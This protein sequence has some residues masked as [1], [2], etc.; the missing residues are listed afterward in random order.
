M[1]CSL[2]AG[3]VTYE[4]YN[5]S[6]TNLPPIGIDSVAKFV[7]RQSDPRLIMRG[8]ILLYGSLAAS[9]KGTGENGEFYRDMESF[10]ETF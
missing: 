10:I 1:R 2:G 8:I 3:F 7:L 9:A 5:Y 4:P 6:G